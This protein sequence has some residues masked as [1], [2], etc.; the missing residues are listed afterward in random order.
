MKPRG[1]NAVGLLKVVP[2]QRYLSNGPRL[3]PP[4][5]PDPGLANRLAAAGDA[6]HA[7][8]G[9]HADRA[10]E[11]CAFRAR[12]GA[13]GDTCDAASDAGLARHGAAPLGHQ[14]VRKFRG[15]FTTQTRPGLDLAV[16]R[17]PSPRAPYSRV[18]DSYTQASSP[19]SS[20]SSGSRS[21]RRRPPLPVRASARSRSK[22]MRRR[23]SP[24]CSSRRPPRRCRSPAAARPASR[25]TFR[26]TPRTRTTGATSPSRTATRPRRASRIT[27]GTD[28]DRRPPHFLSLPK[29]HP[30]SLA[31][32]SVPASK[33]SDCN[34]GSKLRHLHRGS[35]S[36]TRSTPRR[37]CLDRLESR[38]GPIHPAPN[39]GRKM[40]LFEPM[41][42]KKRAPSRA[43]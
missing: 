38:L 19:A 1:A 39:V 43:A 12:R 13:S 14:A 40:P 33:I 20:R 21:G 36:S 35:T 37:R 17:R 18:V 42:Y 25:N 3:R 6:R 31:T 16:P 8:L 10:P 11:A 30:P 29:F 22:T 41:L 23:P 7:P 27:G 32:H 28:D 5:P 24:R 15:A 2:R 4:A 9:S 34:D 26:W